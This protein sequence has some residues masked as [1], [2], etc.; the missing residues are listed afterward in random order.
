MTLFIVNYVIIYIA[1]LILE[2]ASIVEGAMILMTIVYPFINC[3]IW[4]AT[5]PF[6]K[7]NQVQEGEEHASLLSVQ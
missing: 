4:F 6:F 7:R 3:I 2:L 5:G 1:T